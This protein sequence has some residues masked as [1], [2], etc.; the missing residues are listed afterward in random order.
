VL[1]MFYESAYKENPNSEMAARWCVTYGLLPAKV[2]EHFVEKGYGHLKNP[3][4]AK[5]SSAAAAAATAAAAV[6]P[7]GKKAKSASGKAGKDDEDEA[8]V[9]LEEPKA[10]KESNSNTAT[11]AK[12]NGKKRPQL[13]SSDNDE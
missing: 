7:T 3:N 10:A 11:P 4:A 1:R 2:A 8:E 6:K 12:S 13:D 9:K 5:K